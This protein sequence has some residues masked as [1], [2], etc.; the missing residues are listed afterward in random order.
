MNKTS[1]VWG[2]A[3]IVAFSCLTACGSTNKTDVQDPS[4]TDP[5]GTGAANATTD[6]STTATNPGD[7]SATPAN[8]AGK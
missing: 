6:P 4:K 1:W 2:T 3:S 8:S 5:T 7:T